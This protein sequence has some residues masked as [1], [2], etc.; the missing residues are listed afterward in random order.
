MFRSFYLCTRFPLR[1]RA[2]R[3][4]FFEEIPYKQ[5]SSTR[6]RLL[7]VLGKRENRQDLRNAGNEDLIRNPDRADSVRVL[8]HLDAEDTHTMKSLILAQDER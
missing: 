7:T 6:A 3:R 5:Y 1:R 4:A 8:R 2:E